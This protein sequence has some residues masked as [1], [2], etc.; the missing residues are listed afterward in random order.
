MSVPDVWWPVVGYGRSAETAFGQKRTCVDCEFWGEKGG[1]GDD[2]SI[3][4][5]SDGDAGCPNFSPVRRQISDGRR[6]S[7]PGPVLLAAS[8][9]FHQRRLALPHY[10]LGHR[11]GC[12]C[13]DSGELP[14]QV[15]APTVLTAAEWGMR[16]PC[17]VCFGSKAVTHCHLLPISISPHMTYLERKNHGKFDL[18]SQ[19]HLGRRCRQPEGIADDVTHVSFAGLMDKAEAMPWAASPTRRWKYLIDEYKLLVHPRIAGDGPALYEGGLPGTRRPELIS[20]T[21]VRN[22]LVAMHCQ[23]AP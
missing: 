20:A 17:K 19:S 3:G 12:I 2:V 14:I 5:A 9:A 1:N 15:L 23:R 11:L 7:N 22:G 4:C 13:T 10:Q 8:R 18:Q 6:N 16:S 21:P